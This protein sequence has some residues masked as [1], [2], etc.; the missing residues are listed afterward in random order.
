MLEIDLIKEKQIAVSEGI[1]EKILMYLITV[2]HSK[3]LDLIR[4]SK[5][6]IEIKLKKA[7]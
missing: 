2:I 7:D 3:M 4:K 1:T 6:R 5:E